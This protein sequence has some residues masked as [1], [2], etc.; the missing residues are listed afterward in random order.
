MQI[1]SLL[2]LYIFP[3]VRTVPLPRPFIS[4]LWLTS[5]LALSLFGAIQ[6]FFMCSALNLA[7]LYAF[8]RVFD[9]RL[10]YYPFLIQKS[11]F[12]YTIHRFW[13]RIPRFK[14]ENH[15]FYVLVLLLIPLQTSSEQSTVVGYVPPI[16]KIIGHS[17]M[18]KTSVL[19]GQFSIL[20]AFS[21]ESSNKSWDFLLQFA[22]LE[23]SSSESYPVRST[24]QR[25]GGVDLL[26]LL[27]HHRLKSN[28][29]TDTIDS[30]PTNA[31]YVCR[32]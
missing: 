13:Y 26:A 25:H 29:E 3:G 6:A 1:V 23:L 7:R 14:Y 28:T 31:Q 12:W 16:A 5:W 17:S 18:E 27:R 24:L 30:V 19:Q 2:F 15:Q 10:K 8:R 22:L 11:S 21:I 32:I 20:S 9:S 4:I